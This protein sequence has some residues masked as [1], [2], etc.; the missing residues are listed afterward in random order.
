FLFGPRQTG[1]STLIRE[2]LQGVPVYNLLD[3]PTLLALSRFPTR[4]REG[5]PPDQKVAV[6]DEIQKLPSLLDEVHY[7]IEERGMRFLLTGSSARKLRQG[8]VNLLGG[9]ARSQTLHPLVFSELGDRFDLLKALNHGLIPSIYF[10]DSPQ[11]DLE[12]YTSNYLKEEIM[13]EGL[14]RSIPAFSRFLEVAALCNG[15]LINYTEIGNDAQVP[16]TTIH[17]YFQILKDTLIAYELV[18][19][20]RSKT[21][22]P[23]STSKF[24]F[25][26][27]GVVRFLQNRS[28]IQERSPEFGDAFETYFF[29]E[30]RAFVDYTKSGELR[31]W[32]ST[33]GFE[34]DFILGDSIA[35]EIKAKSTIS[36]QDLKGLFALKE[37]KKLKQYFLV[38][39]ESRPRMVEGIQ[40]LPWNLFLKKLWGRDII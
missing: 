30:L 22:K 10:S 26:D 2:Q 24:Y 28:M 29:H 8:G 35:V 6:I 1:K 15:K 40:I 23:I 5:L 32:R 38:S 18:P 36:Q 31:Y 12:S 3:N 7:L 27:G 11:E 16:R 19:W 21:R 17:E 33:S 34:V 25:F 4:L 14:T 9:R 20:K 39:L 13:A 37:E